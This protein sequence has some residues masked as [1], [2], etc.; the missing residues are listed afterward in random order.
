MT[1]K[2]SQEVILRSTGMLVG[3]T[4][5]AYKDLAKALESGADGD[6]LAAQTSFNQLTPD[7]R[8]KIRLHAESYARLLTD[9]DEPG[10]QTA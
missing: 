7:M 5:D 3:K 1:E 9:D 8:T 2:V 6:W 4:S 10:A